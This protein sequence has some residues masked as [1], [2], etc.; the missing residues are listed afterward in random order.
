MTQRPPTTLTR[1]S[2]LAGAA[3][4]AVAPAARAAGEP[5]LAALGRAVGVEVGCCWPGG[6]MPGY[7]DL[8]DRHSDLIVHEW[9]LKPR[10]L[11]PDADGPWRFAEADAIA[12]EARAR[13]KRLHGHTLFWHHEPIGWADSDDFADV[14]RL[15]GGFLRTVV[16]RYPDFVSW[17]VMNEIAE[18]RTVLRDA[19]LLSRHGYRFI[20]FCFRTVHEAAPDARLVLNDYNLECGQGFCGDKRANMLAILKRLKAMGTPVHALGIQA[21]LSSRWTPSPSAAAEFIAEVADLGLEVC[22]SEL[23]V[24]DVDFA[25]D[26]ATRDRQ[27]ADAYES[28]LDAVLAQPAVRR[29]VFWGLSDA[30][31]WISTFEGGES[32]GV[33]ARPALF[34]RFNEPKPAFEAVCRAL[35]AA[36]ARS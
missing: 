18:E 36:P 14:Q 12:E 28:F 21:H 8:I 7:L 26:I 9:Q 11:K 29:V 10:F 15:Y 30:A 32:R 5:S 25:D 23:D 4:C 20:D 24:N 2:L 19:F 17:D 34:D 1:R 27:V 22:I 13:G 33:L 16:A 6:G 3:A 35:R 31:S